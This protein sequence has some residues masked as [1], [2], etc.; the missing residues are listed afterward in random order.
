MR[1]KRKY[2][3][4]IIISAGML[5]MISETAPYVGYYG[6]QRNITE[7][8]GMDKK[9]RSTTDNVAR[10]SR[11]SSDIKKINEDIN[12][13]PPEPDMYSLKAENADIYGWILIPDTAVNYPIVYTGDDYYL[14]HSVEKK[15]DVHGSIYLKQIHDH[16]SMYIFGHN[17]RDGSMFAVLHRY[18]DRGFADSHRYLYVYT[19][20][21]QRYRY[22]SSEI[23]GE[24]ITETEDRG[25]LCTVTC[26][27]RKK[28][29]IVRWNKDN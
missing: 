17:M 27:G 20:G 16:K 19:D 2:A 29:L 11:D 12:P 23:V 13:M 28:R 22:E 5:M 15:S 26:A 7:L 18:S 24:Q 6:E 1:L 14:K 9:I 4:V 21:W 3:A 25:D 8:A 10:T